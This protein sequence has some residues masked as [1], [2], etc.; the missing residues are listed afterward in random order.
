MVTTT[1]TMTETIAINKTTIKQKQPM[2]TTTMTKTTRNLTPRSE[3]QCRTG[4]VQR[5]TQPSFLIVVLLVLLLLVV[6]LPLLFGRIDA[7]GSRHGFEVVCAKTYLL[8]LLT[9]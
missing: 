2:M 8:P 4:R 9:A 3:R 6:V 5:R 7:T 1:T